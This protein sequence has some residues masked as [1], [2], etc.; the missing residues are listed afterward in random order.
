VSEDDTLVH[1]LEQ[2]LCVA[3]PLSREFGLCYLM[4]FELNILNNVHSSEANCNVKRVQ[5]DGLLG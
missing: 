1:P 5:N 2:E 4:E 3:Y